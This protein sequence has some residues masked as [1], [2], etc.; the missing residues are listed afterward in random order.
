MVYGTIYEIILENLHLH[1]LN[2][3]ICGMEKCAPGH[4]FGPAVRE[5]Y[6]LHYVLRGHGAFLS[7][8]QEY[9]LKPGDLFII[10]PG[11]T[12]FYKADEQDPWEYVW[13]GFDCAQAFAPLLAPDTLSIPSAL[14]VF[15]KI[16]GC[17]QEP[18]KNWFICA[19]LYELFSLL[20]IVQ[21]ENERTEQ[22]YVSKAVNYIQSNY[23]QPMRVEAIASGL[24]LSRHY[25]S[26]IFK[27]AT[28]FSPQEYI[29]SFRLSRAAQFM[30]VEGL[31]PG[32]AAR[33]VGYPDVY[34]FSR[35]FSRRYGLPPGRYAAQARQKGGEKTQRPFAGP[36]ER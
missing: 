10:R 26:R 7:G 6:L 33:Q 21:G 34:S 36:Q 1:D 19:R 15:Q 24:G 29:V 14:P 22:R 3:R 27:A 28:G 30:T 31:S 13:V 18:M 16:A 12:T 23:S 25:F 20:A 2:P 4:A 8:A 9:A 5:Y 35:M 11:E 17:H 32:E